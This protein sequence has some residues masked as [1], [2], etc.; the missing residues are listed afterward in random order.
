[1]NAL[2]EEAQRRCVLGAMSI[3]ECTPMNR[4]RS[5]YTMP[6]GGEAAVAKIRR[7][8]ASRVRVPGC[9]GGFTQTVAGR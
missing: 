8:A 2:A 1:M 5:I 9:A 4:T 6:S 7:E 3:F